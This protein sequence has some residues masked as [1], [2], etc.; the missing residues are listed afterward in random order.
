[1]DSRKTQF[2]VSM[3]YKDDIK[4]FLLPKKSPRFDF[5]GVNL[6]AKIFFLEQEKSSLYV[7]KK[8]L[9]IFT[10]HPKI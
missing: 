5:T 7:N 6:V 8:K 2:L 10:L 9:K 1:M 3:K 4:D